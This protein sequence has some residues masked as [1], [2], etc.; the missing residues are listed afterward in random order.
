MFECVLIVNFVVGI[1]VWEWNFK[2]DVVMIEE[3]M[4]FVR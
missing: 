3:G 4:V 1:F 2:M